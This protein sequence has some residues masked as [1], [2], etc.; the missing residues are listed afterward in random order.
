MNGEMGGRVNKGSR[1]AYNDDRKNTTN[2]S[3]E[4]RG[5]GGVE[6]ATDGE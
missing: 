3:D 5:K 1:S 2:L 4:D 6:H